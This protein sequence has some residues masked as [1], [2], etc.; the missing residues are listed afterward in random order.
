MSRK[1]EERRRHKRFAT[2]AAASVNLDNVLAVSGVLANIS[3]GGAFF[4]VAMPKELAHGQKV[5]LSFKLPR[6]T[7]N[8]FM[9]EEVSTESLVVR[10]ELTKGGNG[11]PGGFAMQFIHPL[12]LKIEV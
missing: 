2:N 7:P 1:V 12:Y 5:T 4:S 9:L 8:T 10:K 11:R 6:S 3:D